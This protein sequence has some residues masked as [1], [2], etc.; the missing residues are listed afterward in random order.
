MT[1][2]KTAPPGVS[3][4]FEVFAS[5]APAHATAWMG[6]VR[7]LDDACVLDAKTRDLAYL[8]VLAALRM[9]SGIPFH[10]RQA[11]EH[12]QAARRSSA[13]YCS[14]CRQPGTP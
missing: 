6:L 2:V 13:R 1:S 10:V 9:D 8:A 14:A 12:G 11:R 7:A 3:R 5:Q 4:A